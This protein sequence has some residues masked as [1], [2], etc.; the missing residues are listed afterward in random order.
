MQCDIC[1]RKHTSKLPFN[2]ATCARNALYELRLENART[3][4]DKEALGRQVE[5][6]LSSSS[7]TG[8][9]SSSISNRWDT[10]QAAA[11]TGESLERIQEIQNQADVLK[12][13]I[14]DGRVHIAKLKAS[15]AQRRS[16]YESASHN[17]TARRTATLESVEK[18]IKRIDHR[19]NTL[20]ARTVEARV[21]LCREAANLYGL[22]QRR[23]RKGGV[24]REDYLI[25]GVGIVDLRDLNS[26]LP[27]QITTSITHLAHL[28]ILISHYLSL[29]LPAE[30]TLPHR[31]YP[32]PT[33]FTPSS[34]YSARDVPFPGT[35]PTSSPSASRIGDLPL[36]P[37]PRPLFLEKPLPVLAKEDPAA[38]SL[39][40][41]G[42][43]LLAWDVAWLCRTQGLNISS[44][45]GPSTWEDVCP[46]GRNLWLLLAAPTPSPRPSATDPTTPSKSQS[47]N[48]SLPV[49]LG[50]YSHGTAHTF[51]GTASAA[52]YMRNWK[53]HGPMK[54]VDRVKSALL[55]EMTGAE[56]EV[57]DEREWVG[58]SGEGADVGGKTGEH[59][60]K[61]EERAAVI[62]GEASGDGA[63][64]TS[65]TN[66]T[67]PGTSGWTKLKSR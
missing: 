44:S 24:V 43:T 61:A 17:L 34:S 31:D 30:V 38:Y 66:K 40:V 26:A 14:E 62:A 47:P 50:Q 27:S 2:C 6:S 49:S 3:L 13:D 4:L 51:L 45:A 22:K 19:W 11:R 63:S 39:F 56:W 46:L 5:A 60:G 52:E 32:L 28:L 23:R 54:I 9:S 58:E 67:K 65:T 25:C 12:K 16:D 15:L 36:L 48:N 21:F 33:I 53:L 7:S 1:A 10:E 35:S 20:H 41:E 18:G 57:L 8:Q 29:R 55:G 64:E 42:I 59:G 37:R